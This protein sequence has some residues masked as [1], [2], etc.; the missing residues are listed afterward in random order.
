MIRALLTLFILSTFGYTH[1]LKIF[2]S[3]ENKALHVKAYFSKSAPCQGCDVRIYTPDDILLVE[4]KTDDKGSLTLPL[5]AQKLRILVKA[6]MGH[7]HEV[8]FST[9][10]PIQKEYPTWVKIILGLV[11]ILTFFGGL[12]FARKAP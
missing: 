7:Q 3:E 8:F 4:Q 5:L 6:T 12:K 1:G 2:V 9:T 11:I 10:T